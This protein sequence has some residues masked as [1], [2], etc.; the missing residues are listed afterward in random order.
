MSIEPTPKPLGAVTL[1]GVFSESATCVP[2]KM[3]RERSRSA[4]RRSKLVHV[5]PNMMFTGVTYGDLI[6]MR[7]S[8]WPLTQW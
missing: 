8:A 1:S 5:G 7:L 3:R 2:L 4:Q 6:H